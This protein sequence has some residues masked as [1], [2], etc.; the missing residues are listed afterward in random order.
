M[1]LRHCVRL[2]I[3]TLHRF[4]CQASMAFLRSAGGGLARLLAA[5]A[6]RDRVPALVSRSAPPMRHCSWNDHKHTSKSITWVAPAQVIA[7]ARAYATSQAQPAEADDGAVASGGGWG[8]TKI[9]SVLAA[10]VRSP[11]SL[12]LFAAVVPFRN[13][14]LPP[15]SAILD[16]RACTA[17]IKTEA[18]SD[19]WL[20]AAAFAR[21]P[22]I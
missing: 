17:W 11:C 21:L 10:R 12:A 8:E 1:F 18:A 3:R 13:A 19:I 16:A 22:A 6:A 7:P 4:V 9:S 2:Q 15:K 20:R 5:G 14:P